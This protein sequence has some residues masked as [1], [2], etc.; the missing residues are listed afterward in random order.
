MTVAITRNS[1]R[2]EP[3]KHFAINFVSQGLTR[4]AENYRND[5]I[6]KMCR[7]ETANNYQNIKLKTKIKFQITT[8][9]RKNYQIIYLHITW[10]NMTY[11]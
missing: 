3:H 9:G 10:H 6:P 1:K 5:Y 11:A 7:K 2:K 4:I 8:D